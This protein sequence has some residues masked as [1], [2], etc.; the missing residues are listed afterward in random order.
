MAYPPDDVWIIGDARR[1][2][3]VQFDGGPSVN[4]DVGDFDRHEVGVR[5][6]D[7]VSSHG[8]ADVCAE[9][10]PVG[11]KRQPRTGLHRV[12]L[13]SNV[14]DRTLVRFV[15]ALG[16]DVDPQLTAAGALSS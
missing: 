14:G 16:A 7:A 9:T 10:S 2:M 11:F 8:D 15:G 1:Q 12:K 5:E 6:A 3:D 13:N 4:H